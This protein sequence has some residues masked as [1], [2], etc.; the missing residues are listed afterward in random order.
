MLSLLRINDPLRLLLMAMLLLGMR[1]VFWWQNAPLTLPEVGQLVVGERLAQ[2]G[3]MYADLWDST[4]PLAAGTYWLL[5]LGFGKSVVAFKVLA[6][7]LVLF[8]AG[9][10]N[11]VLLR[12]GLYNEKNYVPAFLYAAFMSLSPDLATLSPTLLATT[13]LVLAAGQLFGLRDQPADSSFFR[14]GLYSAL[15]AL[16]DLA[17]VSFLAFVVLGAANMRT[18]GLR[19]FFLIVYGFGFVVALFAGYYFWFGHLD[20]FLQNCLFTLG[21]SA[22]D[23]LVG[24]PALVLLVG[25]SALLLGVAMVRTFN[26]RGFINFQASCQVLMLLWSGCALLALP[27]SPTLST[28]NLALLAPPFSFFA[29]HFFLLV[30]KKVVAELAFVAYL[31]VVLGLALASLRP[32]AYWDFAKLTVVTASAPGLRQQRILVLG[33]SRHHYLAN[34]LATPYYNWQ[35]AQQH[36]AHLDYYH[37]S[38]AVYQNFCQ[39]PPAVIIDEANFVPILF[40]QMPLL[41]RDYVRD[42]QHPTWYRHK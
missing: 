14:L 38:T 35:L 21:R 13:F 33:Q 3:A 17:T 28:Q 34:S 7:L 37:I 15:A 31:A 41:A 16:S 39:D 36:F 9:V 8:Q 23:L 18:I 5:V 4:P 42:S 30:K 20:D 25:P 22:P 2:G 11:V 10:W 12:F 26:E 19:Q 1:V 29:A 24:V 27:L 40:R 32:A 6:A